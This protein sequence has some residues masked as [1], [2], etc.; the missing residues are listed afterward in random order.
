MR[1][2]KNFLIKIF[3]FEIF[4]RLDDCKMLLLNTLTDCRMLIVKWI[5]FIGSILCSNVLNYVNW[6]VV[7]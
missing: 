4:F 7:Y 3:M 6:M 1:I 2:S 5:V